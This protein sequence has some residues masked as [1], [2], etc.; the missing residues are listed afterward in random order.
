LIAL[1][2]SAN[3]DITEKMVVPTPGNLDCIAIMLSEN[4]NK[5]LSAYIGII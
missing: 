3:L 4:R 5:Y 1:Y 2:S